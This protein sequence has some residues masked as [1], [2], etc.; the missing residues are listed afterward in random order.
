MA[1]SP[2][3]PTSKIMIT[4]SSCSHPSNRAREVIQPSLSPADV[5]N[6]RNVYLKAQRHCGSSVLLF[7][8]SPN[9]AILTADDWIEY[10]LQAAEQGQAS[11]TLYAVVV[12]ASFWSRVAKEHDR[13][14][15]IT[16]DEEQRPE[17][18]AQSSE[19]NQAQIFFSGD[20]VL[21]PGRHLTISQPLDSNLSQELSDPSHMPTT[22]DSSGIYPLPR[23]ETFTL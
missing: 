12:T 1:R 17:R 11:I 5:L 21:L 23:M 6:P 18:G 14:D 22:M 8:H 2:L 3:L 4:H 9:H 10:L 16:F 13:N 19:E 7:H 20:R 15:V